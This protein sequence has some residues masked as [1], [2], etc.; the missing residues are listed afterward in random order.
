[1]MIGVLGS[2]A[3]YERELI[4]ERTASSG[5]PPKPTAPSSVDRAKSF[6]P[7]TSDGHTGKDI[8]KYLRGSRATLYQYLNER[9]VV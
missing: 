5:R 9:G 2:L 3:E 6:R 4:K 1:M 8:A 7:S